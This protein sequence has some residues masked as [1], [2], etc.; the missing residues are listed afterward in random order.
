[1]Y[2][3]YASHSNPV[4]SACMSKISDD[5]MVVFFFVY[6]GEAGDFRDDRENRT[7][8]TNG[9]NGTNGKLSIKRS[10]PIYPIERS[11]THQSYQKGRKGIKGSERVVFLPLWTLITRNKF[12]VRRG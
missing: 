11:V 3:L 4:P 6:G 8:E 9:T 12:V 2:R 10:A 5:Q 7:N 1:M